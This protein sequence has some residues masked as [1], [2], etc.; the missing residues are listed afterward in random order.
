MVLSSIIVLDLFNRIPDL[1][2]HY[3]DEGYFPRK[4]MLSSWQMPGYFRCSSAPHDGTDHRSIH[5]MN[6]S[7]FFQLLLF[8]L[9]VR[10]SLYFRLSRHRVLCCYRPCS[11]MANALDDIRTLRSSCRMPYGCSFAGT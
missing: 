9:N 11:G 7:E 8:L 1:R 6:G 5:L 10:R 2:A 4:L 3:T